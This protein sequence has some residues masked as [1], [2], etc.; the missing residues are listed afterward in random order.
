[1][2]PNTPSKRFHKEPLHRLRRSPSPFRGG[3][4]IQAPSFI[5]G[6]PLGHPQG[7]PCA[8]LSPQVTEGYFRKPF[9]PSR[10]FRRTHT[11]FFVSF[12]AT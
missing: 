8:E 4:Y 5:L 1:M 3:F 11:H 10:R 2:K 7:V 12:F 9:T 6:S